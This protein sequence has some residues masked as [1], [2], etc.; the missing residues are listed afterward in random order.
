MPT[1][2][3]YN[4]WLARVYGAS[5]N[6]VLER[7]YDEWAGEYDGDVGALG[8]LNPAVVAGM[9]GRHLAADAGEILDAGAGTGIIGEVLA[10]VGYGPLVAIDLSEG[11]LEIARAKGAYAECRR[12]VLG[13]RLDFADDRF[14]AVTAS[15]VFT[16]GHAPS[17]AYDELARVTRRNHI[18]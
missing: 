11:M 10:A 8:Y 16:V 4:E 14:A 5:D 3:R 7:A 18:P 6:E 15:G 1:E 9:V 2:P 12:M 13:E 17:D